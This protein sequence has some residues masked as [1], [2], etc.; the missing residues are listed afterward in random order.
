MVDSCF[1]ELN[2]YLAN[3]LVAS[4]LYTLRPWLPGLMICLTLLLLWSFGFSRQW[5][6]PGRLQRLAIL[7]VAGVAVSEG[8]LREERSRL[9][10]AAVGLDD[11]VDALVCLVVA[12]HV[13]NGRSRSL[14]RA[15]QRDA[16][17]SRPV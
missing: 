16:P 3:R 10:A 1:F 5:R 14:G 8:A 17:A 11:L 7:E 13:Y 2:P 12:S 9:R 15:D 4:T 6:K